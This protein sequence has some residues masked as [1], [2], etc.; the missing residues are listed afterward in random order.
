MHIGDYPVD[1]LVDKKFQS[2]ALDGASITLATDGAIRIYKNNSTTERASAA[3]ITF[4]ED[5]D[6][7]V[8]VHHLRIDLS[9]DTDPGFYSAGNSYEVVAVGVVVDGKT[10]NTPLVH[11]TIEISGGV[12]ALLKGGAG[13]A[14]L[15][16]AVAA[17]NIKR[18]QA[19]AKF[20]FV[21]RNATTKAPQP[22]LT[23]TCVRSIDGGAD[24]TG[25][26]A[27]VAQHPAADGRYLV[28]FGAGD[29]DGKVICLK[30]TATGADVTFERIIT[31]P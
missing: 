12:I 18:N 17:S 23:V 24:S 1:G 13:L 21:M 8:G 9:S 26:L 10:V 19:L 29:L 11:F 4:T 27:N 2:Q 15:A 7:I 3:G 30:A 22:G 20:V 31:V 14:T 5:F 6:G 16:A 25:T 28:D